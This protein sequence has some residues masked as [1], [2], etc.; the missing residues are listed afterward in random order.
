MSNPVSIDQAV[1]KAIR[2]RVAKTKKSDILGWE[3]PHKKKL[4]RSEYEATKLDLQIELLKMERWIKDRGKK[5]VMLFEGRDAGGKGGTIKRFTEHMNPRGARVVALEKPDRT[6]LSQW[7]FQRYI[8]H[9]PIDG[10]IVFFDRSWYNRAVVEPVM[11][12]CTPADTTLFL[13]H[14][15]ILEKMLIENGFIIYKFWFSVSRPE[16]FRRFKS[17]EKD[18]L[19]QWKLSPVDLQSLSKWNEYSKAIDRMFEYTDTPESPWLVIR[20][21]DKKRARLN[22]IM[23]VLNSLPYAN[24]NKKVVG[25]PDPRI[26]GPAKTMYESF[27]EKQSAEKQSAEK[28]SRD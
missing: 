9:L 19:K 26:I 17:R 14:A 6:E 1:P 16:Q 12:F 3:Y 11:G 22:C 28:Q 2:T 4:K 27:T 23:H 10:E 15:P 8:Q 25:A 20:S 18:K 21:D 7:F 13:N 5:V 24:K